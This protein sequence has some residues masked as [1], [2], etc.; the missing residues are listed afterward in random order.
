MFIG[1]WRIE[2]SPMRSPLGPIGR[3]RQGVA[4]LERRPEPQ[5]VISEEEHDGQAG[6]SSSQGRHGIRPLPVTIRPLDV[7]GIR[8]RVERPRQPDRVNGQGE[9]ERG[10]VGNTAPA[11][12]PMSHARRRPP[13]SI[14]QANVRIVDVGWPVCQTPPLAFV[15]HRMQVENPRAVS[16]TR[17]E[18]RLTPTR[19]SSHQHIATH[20][21]ARNALMLNS[22][23]SASAGRSRRAASARWPGTARTGRSTGRRW[24]DVVR[25]ERCGQPCPA[26]RERVGQVEEV[27]TSGVEL[28]IREP[29]DRARQ[30]GEGAG[31]C[32]TRVG[33]PDSKL[34][35]ARSS[36]PLAGAP[37]G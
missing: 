11:S 23:W 6:A 8:R 16:R 36:M 25:S 14:R 20:Q 4:G 29:I 18:V 32:L 19:P 7:I 21:A 10:H 17:S 34:R 15:T 3:G 9:G 24:D 1:M 2:N 35:A 22:I 30:R 27:A 28:P 12:R 31:R 13:S 33:P 26:V 5:L 37:A